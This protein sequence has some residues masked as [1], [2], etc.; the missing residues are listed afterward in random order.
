VTVIDGA[1]GKPVATVPVGDRPEAIAV[2]MVNNLVYVANTHGNSVTVIDGANNHVLATLPAGKNP[3]ALA[4]NPSAGKLHVANVD[5]K[6]FTIV[7]VKD[8]RKP[9]R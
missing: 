1:A 4:V 6:S 9:V 5:D 8:I 7:D 2:D 3:Y